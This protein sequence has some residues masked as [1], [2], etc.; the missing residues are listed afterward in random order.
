MH[1]CAQQEVETFIIK[2]KHTF[3]QQLVYEHLCTRIRSRI[4]YHIGT[5]KF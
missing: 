4:D 1:A 3:S 5:C 2:L